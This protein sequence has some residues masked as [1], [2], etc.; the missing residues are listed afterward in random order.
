M[1]EF[2]RTFA[3][4]LTLRRDHRRA[5]LRFTQ[6]EQIWFSRKMRVVKPVLEAGDLLLWLS[7][8]PHCSHAAGEQ[9]IP[10]RGLFVT[11]NLR[12]NADA[13]ALKRRWGNV[14]MGMLGTHNCRIASGM[15]TSAGWSLGGS[16]AGDPLIRS[17]AGDAVDPD[18]FET[19]FR[20]FGAS[21]R[22]P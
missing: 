20:E 12:R 21:M 15:T 1:D 11:G 16:Y 6:D 5:F 3:E 17:M 7:G 4:E 19:A 18:D 2:L 8:V 14:Q 13:R 22:F 9:V 10:R